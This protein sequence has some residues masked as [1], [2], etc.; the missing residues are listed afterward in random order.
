[1]SENLIIVMNTLTKNELLVIKIFLDHNTNEKLYPAKIEKISHN[2]ITRAGV[3]VVCDK[4]M[5]YGLRKFL[6][7]VI[8][9]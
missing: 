7:L 1:M 6:L 5:K 8:H 9:F 4:L 2:K 3:K